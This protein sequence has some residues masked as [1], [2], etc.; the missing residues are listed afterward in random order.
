MSLD[1]IDDVVIGPGNGVRQQ[2][3][4]LTDVDSDICRHI[5]ALDHNKLKHWGC[6]SHVLKKDLTNTGFPLSKLFESA[7]R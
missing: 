6:W 1:L 4:T 3:I 5:S 7:H 2:A